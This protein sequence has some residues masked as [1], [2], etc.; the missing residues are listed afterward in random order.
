MKE[1]YRKPLEEEVKTALHAISNLGNLTLMIEG[2]KMKNGILEK[3]DCEEMK[4]DLEWRDTLD[5]AFETIAA[6]A[7][8]YGFIDAQ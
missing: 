4:V 8:K 3:N 5:K 6:F 7:E 2:N 1:Y